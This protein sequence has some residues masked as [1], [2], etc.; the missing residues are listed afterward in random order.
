[1]TRNNPATR[2]TTVIALLVALM[3]TVAL[4]A[5]GSS[6][7]ETTE[8]PEPTATPATTAAAAATTEA[9]APTEAAAMPEP[10]PSPAP[11]EAGPRGI[12]DVEGITFEVGEGSEVT[13]TVTEQLASLSL[14]NDAVVRTTAL[15]GHVDLSGQESVI[16]ID[17]LQLSSDNSYR[18]RYIHERMFADHPTG[19]FRVQGLDQ[20]PDGFTD[21]EEVSDKVDGELTVRDVT[22]PLT[23][24]VDARD[25]GAVVYIHGRTTFT[26]DQ[27]QIPKPTA[28]SVVS[29]EDEVRVQ[30]L[31][32]VRPEGDSMAMEPTAMPEPAP[33]PEPGPTPAGTVQPAPESTLAPTMPSA[34]VLIVPPIDGDP[35]AF[36]GQLPADEAACVSGA[37]PPDQLATLLGPAGPM[38]P[39]GEVLLGCLGDRTVVRIMLGSMLAPSGG[40]PSPE[41]QACLSAQLDNEAALVPVAGQFRGQL[42]GAAPE[43]PLA[44]FALIPFMQCLNPEEAAAAELGDPAQIQCF[45]EALGP[46]GLAAL[47]EPSDDPAQMGVL[48]QAAFTCGMAGGP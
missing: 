38:G 13:F 48:I 19:M 24:D 8:S 27:L 3:M 1:M 25:D 46:E 39:Q 41:T 40:Q 37:I 45:L 33:S 30:V 47:S 20:L 31:L 2:K 22:V 12:G 16:H 6:D 4:L 15:S 36:L 35:E 5:C 23:F 29:L 14:P 21:G 10:A 43:N 44:M 7:E 42:T 34:G 28:R 32:A 17:L 18:D 9:A 11:A 26:W